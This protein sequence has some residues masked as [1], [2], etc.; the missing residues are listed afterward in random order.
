VR[1]LTV[2]YYEP[3]PAQR[4]GGLEAAVHRLA[5]ALPASEVSVAW[6]DQLPARGVRDTIV[7]FH[8]LWQRDHLRL[9]KACRARGIPYV[10][11]P[12]G[13]LEP[14]AWRHKRWKKLP[15]F[16]LFEKTHLRGAACLLGTSERECAHL[17]TLLPGC[18]CEAIPL[19]LSGDARANYEDARHKLGWNEAETVLLYLS[20]IH[21]KK[22]LHLLLEALALVA[23]PISTRLVIVGGGDDAYMAKLRRQVGRL[24]DAL[25]RIDWIG[26]MWGE[27]RWP[28]F[29]GADL[30]CLPTFSENFGLAVLEAC[31]VGTP[32]LTT[33][34]TPWPEM[35]DGRPAYI[36][37]PTVAGVQRK[38]DRFF[39]A[40]RLSAVERNA[41]SDWA[42]AR[43]NWQ[44][45]A[46]RYV[47][48]YRSVADQ[49]A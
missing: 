33:D 47:A 28:Y 26:E 9:S 19:G 3:P 17:R 38:L 2:H 23:K 16:H 42:H 4:A 1:P 48:L 10:I 45:L 13:M 8:G 25:P 43:F 6:T 32:V 12:H 11:S 20:R 40:E 30:Y 21:P 35:L 39:R 31:Q 18:R 22:G 49:A 34:T 46:S 27:E 7:H 24:G 41:F 5:E 29:Q 36:T 44:S 15:Y 14:W 37:S